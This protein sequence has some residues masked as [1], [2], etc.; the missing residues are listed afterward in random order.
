V[1]K[2]C[3]PNS[4]DVSRGVS[5]LR[6][7][8]DHSRVVRTALIA[9]SNVVVAAEI[10]PGQITQCDVE[11]AVASTQ[12]LNA[13]GHVGDTDCIVNHRAITNG[14][15]GVALG[16]QKE[17]KSTRGRVVEAS[18]VR[19]E[20]TT[21]DCRVVGAGCVVNERVAT[22]EGVEA[23]DV[24]AFLTSRSRLWAKRKAGKR[25]WKEQERKPDRRQVHRMSEWESCRFHVR[26]I[27]SCLRST[28]Q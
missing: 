23:D 4:C 12:R 20:R 13:N 24:A 25:E 10:L 7:D 19:S 2:R 11:V 22:Q 15:V 14:R 26:E 18:G 28:L 9:N 3:L 5:S 16:I 8:M 6:P 1:N 21:T 17:R 27:L